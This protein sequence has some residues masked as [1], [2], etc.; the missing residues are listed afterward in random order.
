MKNVSTKELQIQSLM[1]FAKAL[2]L[3]LIED[4]QGNRWVSA[5]AGSGM[6]K[7][8]IN[9]LI[10]LHNDEWFP[11]AAIEYEHYFYCRNSPCFTLSKYMLNK[12]NAAKIVKR[13]KGRYHKRQKDIVIQSDVVEFMDGVYYTLFLEPIVEKDK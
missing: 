8:S 6:E 7:I 2:D 5:G 13:V 1:A 12:A 10:H 9:T 11:V 4:A 3:Q